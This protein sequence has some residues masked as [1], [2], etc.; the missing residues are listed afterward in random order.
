VALEL[1]TD[2]ERHLRDWRGA[3]DRV[4]EMTVSIDGFSETAARVQRLV[5]ADLADVTLPEAVR[6]LAARLAE[7]RQAARQH[8]ALTAESAR[9]RQLIKGLTRTRE[10]AEETLRALRTLA[11]VT[12]DPALED[13]IARAARA[14]ALEAEIATLLQE[15][16]RLGD[17]RSLAALEEEASG[18]DPDALPGRI[19]AIDTRLAEIAAEN[20][21]QG[22]RL[23]ELRAALAAMSRG[24][25]AAAASQTM[26]DALADIDD[27]ATRYVRLRLAHTLLR[28]GIDR[29]RR[30]Q[31]AP[32]LTR[33][34]EIFCR[35]T[36]GRY[37]K[38][39]ADEAEDGQLVLAA[40][41][42]DGTHCPAERLSEGTSDQLYLALRLAAIESHAAVADPLPFVADDLLV[43]FDDQRALAALEVLA[44][45]TRTTQV[46]LFTHHAHVADMA[47]GLGVVQHLP[48]GVA[49]PA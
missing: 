47:A 44:E 8:A 39:E 9:L 1:W 35:L 22:A 34:G 28:A 21:A 16:A 14:A 19:G 33:A 27:I 7:A 3:E 5:A 32:L 13:A 18:I 41:R 43:N 23:S 40:L 25:E 17:G 20:T 46:I 49:V 38:L 42:P 48:A 4:A 36:E 37:E 12:D 15:L 31:Q 29:F 11:G 26:Q 45:F 24:H 6:T 10:A 30:Q 2:A